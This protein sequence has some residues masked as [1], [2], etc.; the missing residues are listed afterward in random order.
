MANNVGRLGVVLGLNTAEFTAGIENA[1]K[2]LQQFANTVDQY[3]KIGATALAAMSVAAM[4][5]ADDIADVADANDVAIDT[6]VKLRAALDAS[7]GSADKAG[8]LLSAFTKA[9]DT[10]ANGSFEAQKSFKSV[11]VSLKDI[12]SMT[13]EQLLGKVLAGLEQMDDTVTRNAKAME[14]FSKA[15]KGVAFDKF[16]QEMS[17][18]TALTNEQIE[19]VKAGAETWDNLQK[20]INKLQLLFVNA[21]GPSL[22]A[23]NSQISDQTFPKI[24]MLGNAFNFL[25][26]N[27]N[28]AYKAMQSV[29]VLLEKIAGYS[30]IM[31]TYGESN[32]GAAELKKL[33]EETNRRL[34]ELRNQQAEFDRVLS[35]EKNGHRGAGFDDPRLPKGTSGQLRETTV[36][37][38]SKAKTAEAEAK[39]VLE[40]RRRY[41]E[42]MMQDNEDE[43]EKRKTFTEQ[44]MKDNEDAAEKRYQLSLKEMDT[45]RDQLQLEED[46]KNLQEATAVELERVQFYLGKQFD[47]EK[48]IF[49]LK[50]D[51]KHL[52]ASEMNYAERILQIRKEYEDKEYDI[53]MLA[54][55]QL[56][57]LDE[58]AK[59]LE[60]NNELRQRAIEQ[61]REVLTE[62]RRQTEGTFTE[63]VGRA[64][65]DY[66][67]NIPTQLQMG[68]QAFTAVIG[69]MDMALQNF[70]RSGKFSFSDFTRSVIQDMILIQARAQ[71]MAMMRGVYSMFGGGTPSVPL[72]NYSMSSGS[73]G[74]GG[75]GLQMRANGGTVSGNSPYMVGER[76]PELFVPNM[77]GAVIPNNSLANSVGGGQTVNYNGPYIANMSAIDTQTGV[78]FLAK[79]KQTIWASYQSANRS[80]PVSR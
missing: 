53:K 17:K 74:S 2:K 46:K 41:T 72:G 43:L 12:G 78:Q 49:L 71:M 36:G 26:S 59:R 68:Q 5:F 66:I 38:D 69:N 16:A 64:F 63:G 32:A 79:N 67:K 1:G 7:G 21:L 13:Q 6:V 54:K 65:D 56:L 61:A 15:A 10:A 47:F 73:S 25:A 14:F 23:I 37:V 19:A 34:A 35:G 51:N 62:T 22:K 42:Q 33:D 24:E 76:G 75:L 57:T 29:A 77:S 55:S 50:R 30:V 48:E 44:M 45:V 31:Q 18:T 70:V 28:S 4:K 80:V 27:V 52:S 40:Q 20:I 3:A 39:R 58:E 60:G 11:G 9:I 8:V